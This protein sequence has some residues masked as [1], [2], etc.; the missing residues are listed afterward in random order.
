M[1]IASTSLSLGIGKARAIAQLSGVTFWIVSTQFCKV[2]SGWGW[3]KEEEDI[4][5]MV[6]YDE[7]LSDNVI[8]HTAQLMYFTGGGVL[9]TMHPNVMLKAA[10]TKHMDKR[11]FVFWGAGV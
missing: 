3:L 6:Y 1:A 11:V 4:Y 8:I 5:F 10:V 9:E 2:F 7:L